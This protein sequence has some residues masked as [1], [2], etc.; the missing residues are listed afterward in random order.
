MGG[1]SIIS[2]DNEMAAKLRSWADAHAFDL[3]L[4]TRAACAPKSPRTPPCIDV[5]SKLRSIPCAHCGL[6]ARLLI[7]L[8]LVQSAVHA[9]LLF[10]SMLRK[11]VIFCAHSACQSFVSRLRVRTGGAQ[12]AE[13]LVSSSTV[14]LLHAGASPPGSLASCDELD[15]PLE[16]CGR[17][18]SLPKFLRT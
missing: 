16:M 13:I 2:S 14:L 7:P 8:H 3:E 17:S 5:P 6:G 1:W 12:C 15:M 4:I 11:T 10:P 9:C 18:L